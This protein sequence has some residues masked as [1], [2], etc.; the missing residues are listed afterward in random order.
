MCRWKLFVIIKYTN[1]KR[2]SEPRI[3]IHVHVIHCMS[4][5]QCSGTC[6]VESCIH[7]GVI[8]WNGKRVQY[9]SPLMRRQ[10]SLI[11]EWNRQARTSSEYN[12]LI[13]CQWL[14][15]KSPRTHDSHKHNYPFRIPRMILS[16]FVSTGIQGTYRWVHIKCFT[17][18]I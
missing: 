12:L 18:K 6:G 14:L 8:L 5:M 2:S 15:P 9:E 7:E 11:H 13:V 1:N 17:S 10:V 16:Y 4:N 3:S